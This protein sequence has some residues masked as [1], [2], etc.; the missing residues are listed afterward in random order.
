MQKD[1][2]VTTD[3]IEHNHV[4]NSVTE[5]EEIHDNRVASRIRYN[6]S[7]TVNYLRK[8]Y[9][10][11]RICKYRGNQIIGNTFVVGYSTGL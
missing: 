5:V 10:F 1:L 7:P 6:N 2:M 11:E 9:Y 3:T 8:I 4:P